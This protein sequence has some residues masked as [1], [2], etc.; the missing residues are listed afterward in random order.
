LQRSF[1]DTLS[2]TANVNTETVSNITSTDFPNHYPGESADATWST[3]GFSKQFSINFHKHSPNDAV[4]SLVGIDASIANAFRRILLAELP[5][6]A[7]E[8]VFVEQNTSIIQD[9]VLAHRLGLIPLKGSKEGL[10][11]LKWRNKGR[12]EEGEKGDVASDFNTV[13][14]ELKVTCEWRKGGQDLARRGEGDPEKLYENANGTC[15]V[16][17]RDVRMGGS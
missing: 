5:T 16:V 11:W 10:K 2:Q 3:D 8:D 4:F 17:G 7:I 14:M 13:V 6:L 15:R 1:S 9:E 12:E